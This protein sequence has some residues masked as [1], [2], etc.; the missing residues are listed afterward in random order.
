MKQKIYA[1]ILA[2]VL[3]I[4]AFTSNASTTLPSNAVTTM[5]VANTDAQKATRLAEIEKRV[6][7]IKNMDKSHLSRQE[8]KALRAELRG[9]GKDARSNGGIYLSVGAIIIIILL[10]ILLL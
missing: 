10:L 4:I 9:L 3:L 1:P 7:E 6:Y 5:P 8:R 2:L